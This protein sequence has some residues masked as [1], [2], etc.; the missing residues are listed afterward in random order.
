M[1]FRLF[2][3]VFALLFVSGMAFAQDTIKGKVV[4]KNGNPVVGTKITLNNGCI[5]TTDFDGAFEIEATNGE[6]AVA[7]CI[8]LKKKRVRMSDDMVIKLTKTSDWDRPVATF[9][10]FVLLRG[11][12]VPGDDKA[13]VGLKVGMVRLF[14]WYV[15][16]SISTDDLAGKTRYDGISGSRRNDGYWYDKTS[17]GLAFRQLT[18]GAIFRLGCPLHLF[19]GGGINQGASYYDLYPDE[20]GKI[21]RMETDWGFGIAYDLGFMLSFK[22]FTMDISASL[23]LAIDGNFS[24]YAVPIFSCG[25][26]YKF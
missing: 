11:G 7:K 21:H 2:T 26:G 1:R 15:S 20:S 16:L 9:S 25:V 13:L 23:P 6:K 18:A 24:Y 17:L 5:A 22:H 19:V 4:D 12:W 14:G 8:G 3:A 10:P